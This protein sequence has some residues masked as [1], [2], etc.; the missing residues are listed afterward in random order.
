MSDDSSEKA[1]ATDIGGGGQ[2]PTDGGDGGG[3]TAPTPRELPEPQSSVLSLAQLIGA[4]IHALVDAEAQSAMATARFIRS[5]GFTGNGDGMGD[6]GELQ[7]ARFKRRH[8]GADG[9][10]EEVE[11]QIPLLSMLPIPALQIKDAELDY[12][13]KIVQTEALPQRQAEVDQLM[14]AKRQ[15][16]TGEPPATLRATFAREQGSNGRRSVDML[17]K[18]KL[19]IEQADMPGGL[20]QLLALASE[21]SSQDVLAKRDEE[22]DG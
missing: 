10:D 14:A 22:G 8:R 16:P 12:T 3:T 1:V 11:V 6:L 19:R 5:V 21:S 9:S 13:V 17:V 2:P 18:M 20:A 7:M 4:P 15:G